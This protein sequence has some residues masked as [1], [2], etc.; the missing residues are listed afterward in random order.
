MRK[1]LSL[2]LCL[3]LLLT[4]IIAVPFMVQ[5]AEKT[6]TFDYS[7][8]TV[9]PYEGDAAFDLG[10][11][12]D[13]EVADEDGTKVLKLM[14]QKGTTTNAGLYAVNNLD[15]SGKVTIDT[16][17]R[18]SDFVKTNGTWHHNLRVDAIWSNQTRS[19]FWANSFG[20]CIG[21]SGSETALVTYPD[22]STKSL[23]NGASMINPTM[24][25][26]W[27]RYRFE[28]DMTNSKIK[29]S[30]FADDG[31][32]LASAE[33][34]SANSFSGDT[35]QGL[36]LLM[37]Y[38]YI[39]NG[40]IVRLVDISISDTKVTYTANEVSFTV[41]P[42]GTVKQ[43]GNTIANGDMVTVNN[44][45]DMLLDLVPEEGY[46]VDRV[47]LS[48][49]SELTPV[50]NTVTITNITTDLELAITFRP[51]QEQKPLVSANENVISDTAYIP[52]DEGVAVFSAIIYCTLDSG[53]GWDVQS[54]GVEITDA[55][56]TPLLLPFYAIENITADGKFGI[57]VY[58][59][60]LKTGETY[61]MKPYAIVQNGSTTETVYGDPKSFTVI[62]V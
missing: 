56:G 15:L 12:V 13:V 57:R 58:G 5:A 26:A 37:P 44:G 40:K 27:Y 62:G 47:S 61:Y 43:D 33:W 2:L 21:A 60:A 20:F 25:G 49:G 10:G 38:P 8:E 18:L 19:V 39:E 16:R 4:S 3:C 31:S 52:A 50:G 46:E 45:A 53:Y 6:E 55:D 34:T 17:V 35:F 32:F 54:V 14:P 23:M 11:T 24:D 30:I 41:G 36:R 22:G 59:P 29:T 1:F 7:G 42:N 28:F 51:K 48:D 9:G